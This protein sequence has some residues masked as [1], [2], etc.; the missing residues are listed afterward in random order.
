MFDHRQRWLEMFGLETAAG[1]FEQ[2]A[3]EEAF[4][5][6]VF[7]VVVAPPAPR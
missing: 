4:G 1:V 3:A 7:D 2:R 5:L 6:V